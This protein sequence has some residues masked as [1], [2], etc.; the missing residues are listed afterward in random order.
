M[1]IGI[2]VRKI[3]DTG[4][5]TYIRNIL[6]EMFEINRED[7]FVLFG[8]PGDRE[9]LSLPAERVTWV[10]NCS[11]KYS[12]M[13]HLSLPWM[14]RRY[15]V[16]VFHA[17][18]YTLPFFLTCRS[19]VTIHDLIHLQFPEYLPTGFHRGYAR[20][21]TTAAAKKADLIITV[22]ENSRN[23]IKHLLGVDEEKVRVIYNGVE[24]KFF[25]NKAGWTEKRDH[26]LLVTSP[27]PHKN[28]EGALRAFSMISNRITQ[29][30]IVAGEPPDNGSPIYDLIEKNGITDRVTFR[31]RLSGDELRELYAGALI[32]VSLSRYEGFGLPAIEAMAS[33]AAVVLSDVSSHPEVAGDAAILVDPD[34][35]RG[36]S[37][38]MFRLI[39]DATLRE[40]YI[41]RGFEQARRFSWK[42]AARKTLECY[43]HHPSTG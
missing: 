17:P 2:D 28:L 43:R 25:E 21:M 3:R 22:S 20:I 14:A 29:E 26:I 39:S 31:G 32:L 11:A 42:D 1:N 37:E 24:E 13:E 6:R 4:I 19:V 16:D 30:L 41:R 36:A 8:Y 33:G 23:D 15:G 18:H 38:A 7:S 9:V 10:K 12:L 35:T 40:E 34:D 5:G 27:K